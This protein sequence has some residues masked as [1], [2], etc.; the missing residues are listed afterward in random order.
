MKKCTIIRIAAQ[1]GRVAL[2]A[3]ATT[4]AHAAILI[5]VMLFIDSSA[6]F[7]LLFS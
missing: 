4:A 5:I 2:V 7:V 6:P 1:S 3:T